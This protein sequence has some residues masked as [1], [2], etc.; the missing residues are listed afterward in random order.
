MS[1]Y[2]KRSS[3]G[4]ETVTA[5]V[6]AI[7][8]VSVAALRAT[9]GV[10]FTDDG[11]YVTVP[12]RIAQGAR[13]FA[14]DAAMQPPGSLL[15]VPFVAFWRSAFGLSGIV[16]AARLYYV[17]L[18]AIV[19]L[20]TVRAIR[21]SFGPVVSVVAV[22][23]VLLAPAYNIFA[24]SYNTAAQLALMLGFALAFA[25][26]RDGGR[27]TAAFAGVSAVVACISYPPLVIALLPAAVVAAV[28]LRK[29]RLWVWLLGGA[30]VAAGIM[31]AWLMATVP[32]ADF[33]RALRYSLGA[34]YSG[35]GSSVTVWERAT[36][37]G[38]QLELLARQH[39]WWPAAALSIAVAVPIV[40]SRLRAWLAMALPVAV[41]LPGALALFRGAEWTFGVPVMSFMLA[42][43]L[44]LVPLACVSVG[45]K[46][47][48]T[49]DLRRL[50]LLSGSF[51]AVAIP[52]VFLTTNSG[53][54][55]GV[56]AVGATPLMLAVV[57]V[58]L[59]FIGKGAGN[60]TVLRA[61]VGL[62]IIESLLLF[63]LAYRD[64]SP[65]TL[66]SRVSSGAVAGIRTTPRQAQ[67]IADIE[68]AMSKVAGS[69]STV[70]VVNA[71]LVYVLTDATPLTYATWVVPG[72]AD[73]AIVE[74][75]DREGATPDVVVVSR[76]L[77]SEED[78]SVPADKNDP[79]L[80]W[81]TRH[82]MP[83][84]RAGYVIMRRR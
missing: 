63:G 78:D 41:A 57:A 48:G 71:P 25:A 45:S 37:I 44:A 82:Y 19:G 31:A 39:V 64:G 3:P 80:S 47:Q 83:T 26:W 50:L 23:A 46:R 40:P 76:S 69:T 28:A 17:G 36:T 6:I 29:R 59:W 1:A 30:A 56:P 49:R 10:S 2:V 9:F 18:A 42:L 53:F 84:E 7:L 73:G 13:L 55:S 27:F 65:L 15:A 38:F 32:F 67:S 72:P 74:Y 81:I 79:L 16:L 58:W 54:V 21:P 5:V 70:L 60:R 52:L 61:G 24:V 35:A 14:D 51:S 34:A 4:R 20:F 11:Y 43:T 22:S 33:G 68:R 12:L 66:T 62:L 8:V 75:F 77:L